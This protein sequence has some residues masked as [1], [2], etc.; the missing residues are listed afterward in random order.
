MNVPLRLLIADDSENDVQLLLRELR[1]AGYAPSHRRVDTAPAMHDAL[2]TQ[3][4][5]LVI[6]DYSMPEFRG[7]A[8]LA[9]L[10]ER[11]LDIPFIFVSGTIKEDVAIEAMRAGARD[12]VMKGNLARLLPAIDRELRGADARRER[13]RLE[14]TLRELVERAPVGIYRSTPAGKILAANAAMA[15][16]LGYDSPDQLLHLDLARDVYAD[17]AER[18]RLLERDTYTDREYDEVEATWKSRDGRRVNVQ[19]SVRAA[20]DASGAIEFYETFV[21]DITEQRRFEAQFLQA[22]KMEAVGR[23]AGGVAH[24]FNNLLTVIL[25]YSSLLLEDWSADH[26]DRDDVDQI[27]KAAEG[28]SGLT[29]QLLAFSRQ[30]VLDPRITDLNGVVANIEKMLGRLLGEDIRVVTR[31]ADDIGTVKVDSGQ[32][33]QVIVNLAV[34]ARDAMPGGGILTIETANM[35][36]DEAYVSGHPIAAPGS[37]VMLAVSDTG[38]GMDEATQARIFEPFFTTKGPGKGTGLGLATVHGIVRQSSGFIWVY[39]EIGRGT[40]F[41]IYLPRMDANVEAAPTTTAPA[42]KTGATVL[43][44]EDM[45]SVRRVTCRMLA[46]QGYTVLEAASGAAA[47]RLV[48]TH[49]GPIDL[50]LTDVVMPELDGRRLA[51]QLTALRPG[52]KVLYMS[53]YT[54]HAIVNNG[55]LDEGIAYL[56]KPLTPAALY[57]KVSDVLQA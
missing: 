48:Q 45:D 40:S 14:E 31:L 56:Q 49:D 33:E 4:W 7:T 47:L 15:R 28:A 36:M 53:G 21:K 44:V 19:L 25:S 23:L 13:R 11:G 37:Y 24:D 43:V 18:Q 52:V 38:T 22:Q 17:P 5:D 30:Q 2:D 42:G 1:R 29:R 9:L 27:R 10:Q 50:L 12:Y 26:P 3:D 51:D 54:D 6:G 35:E 57:Q 55:I 16:I 32:L 39:S 34:N 20:R 41:K 46:R 8:A